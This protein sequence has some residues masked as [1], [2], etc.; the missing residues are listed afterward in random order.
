MLLILAVAALMGLMQCLKWQGL[1]KLSLTALL[2]LLAVGISPCLSNM[3]QQFV[4]WRR[5]VIYL[6]MSRLL[7]FVSSLARLQLQILIFLS[8]KTP[9]TLSSFSLRLLITDHCGSRFIYTLAY[10][11]LISYLSHRYFHCDIEYIVIINT[12]TFIHLSVSDIPDSLSTSLQ[13]LSL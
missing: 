5:M 6:I 1:S 9:L 13:Q 10:S 2:S 4:C 7:L 3:A 12:S 11:L 8:R